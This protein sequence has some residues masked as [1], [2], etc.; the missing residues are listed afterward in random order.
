MG[1]N[2]LGGG[3]KQEDE[4]LPD[5]QEASILIQEACRRDAYSAAADAVSIFMPSCPLVKCIRMVEV[6]IFSDSQLSL[7]CRDQSIS[8]D[9]HYPG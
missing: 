6:R 7:L 4:A 2:A 5:R 9:D 8:A 3:S 1:L